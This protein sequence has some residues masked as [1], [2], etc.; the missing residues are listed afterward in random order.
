MSY[1]IEFNI[2]LECVDK[3]E[4]LGRIEGGADF[5]LVDTVGTYGGNRHKIK[6]ATTIP[7][8]EVADR[9]REL[10]KYKEIIVYC[11]EKSCVASKKVAAALKMLNVPNVKVYEGGIVEWMKNSL[12]VEEL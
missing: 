11:K 5:V 2:S 10:L 9:R 7:Y 6:G 3:D 12:P 1:L 4:L 8:P